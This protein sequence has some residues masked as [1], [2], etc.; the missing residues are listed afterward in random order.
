MRMLDFSG[1]PNPD[2]DFLSE[3]VYEGGE[4]IAYISPSLTGRK[5]LR[6]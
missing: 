5:P 6:V 4:Y 2:C 1:E 3:V